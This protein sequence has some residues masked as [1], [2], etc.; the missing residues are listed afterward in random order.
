MKGMGGK[1]G[2]K[3]RGTALGI[4][5]RT[6][7]VFLGLFFLSFSG[8]ALKE[9]DLSLL[10][11]LLKD[12]SFYTIGSFQGAGNFPLQYAKF[13]KGVGKNGSLIFMSGKG[14][15]LMKYIELFYDFYLQGWSPIYT[16]DH[17]GQGFSERIR[18]DSQLVRWG[19]N[20]IY[21]LYK[22]D[23]EAFIELVLSERETAHSRLFLIAHSMGGTIALDYLQNHLANHPFQ[24]VVFSS[25]MIDIQSHTLYFF[26]GLL[27][28]YCSFMPC[29][30]KFPSLRSRFTQ[31]TFTDSP[32]RYT[33]SEY[34]VTKA[35]PETASKG[36]S[37]HWLI[38]SLE[39]GNQLLSRDRIQR[40]SV[41]LLILQSEHEFFVS[42]KSQH[43]FC[44]ANPTCCHIKKIDGKHEI[45]LEADQQRNQAIEISIGFFLNSEKYRKKC[46]S[47]KLI[48]KSLS[49][50]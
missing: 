12:K 32:A 3:I 44:E 1:I 34:L 42:N 25:P 50:L 43:F 48:E 8:S 5:L 13:G 24:A 30:W 31:K 2:S 40:L 47:I 17:R 45:F 4:K 37:F 23:L 10:Y 46:R 9:S 49:P 41:P 28:G 18:L 6:G 15:N 21:S 16:Y 26:K 38:D 36:T 33:I 11:K 22:K 14:E 29:A 7:G 20:S 35:F 19:D 39:I 27:I